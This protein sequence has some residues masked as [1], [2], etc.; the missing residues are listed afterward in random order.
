[1]HQSEFPLPASKAGGPFGLQLVE[2]PLFPGLYG[3]RQVIA[4]SLGFLSLFVKQNFG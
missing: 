4:F 2:D 3:I 1:M